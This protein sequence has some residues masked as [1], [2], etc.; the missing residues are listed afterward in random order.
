[1]A[2]TGMGPASALPYMG[3]FPY[4]GNA[5]G[6]RHYPC[7][8]VITLDNIILLCSIGIFQSSEETCHWVKLVL[9]FEQERFLGLPSVSLQ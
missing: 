7:Q 1:M 5:H 2:T 6:L 4:Y 8:V 3:P 9:A